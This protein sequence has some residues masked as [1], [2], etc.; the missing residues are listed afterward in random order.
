[1]KE[2]SFVFQAIFLSVIPAHQ[3]RWRSR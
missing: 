1:L 3:M 2:K